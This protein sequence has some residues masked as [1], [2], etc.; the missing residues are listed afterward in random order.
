MELVINKG[1]VAQNLAELDRARNSTPE[2]KKTYRNLI[3][4]GKCYLPYMTEFGLAFAPSRFIGYVG[5]TFQLH[6]L[7]LGKHGNKTNHALNKIYGSEPV[8]NEYLHLA[9]RSFCE[10]IGVARGTNVI[11]K[12]W[13]SDDVT[14]FIAR[15]QEQQVMDTPGISD[16]EKRQIILARIGQGRFRKQLIDHW[17]KCSATGCSQISILKASHI[18]PWSK[19][20][21]NER[22]DVYNGLLLNPNLDALFDKGYVTFDDA[23]KIM[24]SPIVSHSDLS[25]LNCSAELKVHLHPE[26]RKYLAWHREH[27]FNKR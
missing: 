5:N 12:Y 10:S 4:R 20:D 21:N 25:V 23:G 3:S 27:L 8:H 15:G 11:R 17:G 9:F 14:E 16:T 2:E 1:Q 26:H 19:S 22:L 18:K 6:A 13:V 24:I 7:N